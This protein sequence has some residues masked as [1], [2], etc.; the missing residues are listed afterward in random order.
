MSRMVC[1][2]VC[3]LNANKR[4]TNRYTYADP[5]TTVHLV[6]WRNA[7]NIKRTRFS[8]LYAVRT[9]RMDIIRN[10]IIPCIYARRIRRSHGPVDGRQ[11]E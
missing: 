6:S 8:P 9:T 11:S 1:V 5:D 3:E 2:C 7:F 4:E 10:N